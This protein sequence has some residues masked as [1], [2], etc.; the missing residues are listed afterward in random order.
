MYFTR[1]EGGPAYG[2]SSY[3]A[4]IRGDWK[5]LRNN[6]FSPYEL[7]N[8]KD[9]PQETRNLA[10]SQRKIVNELLTALRL[11]IQRGGETPWQPPAR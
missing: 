10:G 8:L 4:I 2:G 11:Q 1:R 3:E 7:Y 5:L 9:D 6:P